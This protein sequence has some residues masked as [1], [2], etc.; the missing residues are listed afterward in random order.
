MDAFAIYTSL[1]SH[2]ET[3][4]KLLKN[5][6]AVKTGFALL[7][8]STDA[9]PPLEAQKDAIAAFFKDCQI[10]WSSR[11]ISYRVTNVPRKVGRLTG[12]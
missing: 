1:R 11:W 4:E 7:P 2:L 10:E 3:N 6:Q 8:V 5:V 12:S 9:L